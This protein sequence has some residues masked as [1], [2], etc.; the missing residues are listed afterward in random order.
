MIPL[1]TDKLRVSRNITSN[2][3]SACFPFTSSF[4]NL[5]SDGIMFGVNANNHIPIILDQYKFANYN[6]IVLG[7]SGGGKS[8]FTKLY[9]IR[10]LLKEMQTYIIDPQGEYSELTQ[11]YDGQVIEISRDSKTSINPLDLMGRDFGDKILSLMDLFKIMLGELTEVQKNA[12]DKALIKTYADKHIVPDQPDTWTAKPPTIGE[13]YKTLEEEQRRAGR[14]E[15]VTFDALL[16]RLRIYATGSFSF[17]NKPTSINLDKKII[18]FNI[19]DMPSQVKPTMMFLI[20]DYLYEVCQKNKERKLVVVDEAWTLLRHGEHSD[21]L[22]RICKTARKFGT[23]LV[24]VTQEVNDL[25]NSQAGNTVLANTSWKLLLRQEPAVILE[26]GEKFRLKEEEKKF[27]LTADKGEGLLFAMN[28]R[29][30]VKIVASE[31]EYDIITTN[32]DELK[33][34]ELLREKLNEEDDFNEEVYGLKQKYYKTNLLNEKQ[35]AFLKA[36]GYIETRQ[37]SLEPGGA[38]NY[39]VGFQPQNESQDHAFLVQLLYEEIRKYTEKVVRY[40]VQ[41]PDLVFIANGKKCAIEVETGK[42][43]NQTIK[44]KAL[45]LKEFNHGFFVLTD[46]KMKINYKKHAPTLGRFEAKEKIKKLF[47]EYLGLNT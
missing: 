33:K 1:A 4:L 28:D 36:Q 11:K 20:L 2:A 39:L 5:N 42:N 18:S 37:L 6:G 14:M 24:L 40:T 47:I 38:Y 43:N 17:L 19:K 35:V 9:I 44:E 27:V 10:N 30:P 41:Q 8:F 3:L 21:Y 26:L 31:K 13:L 46:S 22:Y 32:P 25:L 15:K 12:L 7:S 45:K 34:R 29:I 16:N 23:G